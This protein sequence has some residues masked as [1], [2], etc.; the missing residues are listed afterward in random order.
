MIATEFP[1]QF[2]G[3]ELYNLDIR[4]EQ[5]FTREARKKQIYSQAELLNSVRL[6]AWA[7]MTS[8]SRKMNDLQRELNELEGREMVDETIQDNWEDLKMKGKG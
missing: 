8:F 2:P 4:D 3:K 1:G 6:A 7:D 5:F